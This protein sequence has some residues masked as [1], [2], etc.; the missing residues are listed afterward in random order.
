MDV[1]SPHP[2]WERGPIQVPGM[3]PAA[4]IEKTPTGVGAPL[5]ESASIRSWQS[6]P[7][8][9]LPKSLVLLDCDIA[10]RFGMAL[11]GGQHIPFE[12]LK[13]VELYAIAI[14]VE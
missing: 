14:A 5:N 12:G 7:R 10:L 2:D 6:S 1:L 11:T 4:D 8:Q 9:S 3:G 13:V